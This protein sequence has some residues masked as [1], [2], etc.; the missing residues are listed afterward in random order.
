MPRKPAAKTQEPD[1]A[2]VQPEDNAA[3]QPASAGSDAGPNDGPS[4]DDSAVDD[5]VAGGEVAAESESELPVTPEALPDPPRHAPHAETSGRVLDTTT[6]DTVPPG[7]AQDLGTHEKT[8]NSDYHVLRLT[9]YLREHFP[10]QMEVTRQFAEHP[11]DVAIRLLAGLSSQAPQ[12]AEHC[13][14]PYCNRPKGHA[15]DHGWV[16]YGG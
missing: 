10:H 14:E 5:T 4:A 12:V 11:V 2:S 1:N 13:K 3:E 15:D 16:N 7:S 8:G 6:S 9:E